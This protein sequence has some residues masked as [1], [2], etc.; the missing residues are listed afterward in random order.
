MSDAPLSDQRA[1]RPFSPRDP[2]EPHRAATPLELLFDLVSVIAIAS[3]AAG[4][5]HAI[6]ENHATQ[7]VITFLIAF[8]AI[9]WAW[10][11]YSW[12]A[13]AYDNDGPFFRV[14]TFV[15]MTGALLL[16]AGIPS[17]FSS[18]DV[19][20]L[21]AG[22]VIMRIGMVIFW[23]RAALQDPVHAPAAR[24]YAI[25]IFLAQIYWV[26]GL[27]VWRPENQAAFY[28][29]W[30]IGM[31]AEL[32]VPAIAERCVITPWHRHHMIE[33]YG[34]LNIIVLGE[35]LLAGSMAIEA[36]G[37]TLSFSDPLLHIALSGLV[38]TFSM[39]WLYFC[40]EE[41]LSSGNLGRAILWGYGHYIIY[42]S[43]AAVGAGLALLVDIV[44][45]HAE[46]SVR[47]GDIAVAIPLA[48]YMLGLWFTRDRFN[49]AFPQ[50]LT[51]PAFAIFILVAGFF[52]P[53]ALEL[54]ALA[55][56]LC[57]FFRYGASLS[58]SALG[59]HHR[60]TKEK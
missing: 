57:V 9:W 28:A 52:L 12:Y 44:S 10:M 26:L 56:A 47:T 29:I 2:H 46:A 54:M 45:G 32:A 24:F 13:S 59:R 37:A 14:N 7:G 25:G 41:H 3:A 23:L 35:I 33:R 27:I 36:A 22:Y 40:R 1:C 21:I 51:L 42:A 49:L 48:G 53:A 30:I 15:I 58:I 16:A 55:S 38:I 18:M 43:G 8:F 5:H 60:A 4:L 39:W 11:N 31:A 20:L 50:S 19:R 34:L 6:A 17:L